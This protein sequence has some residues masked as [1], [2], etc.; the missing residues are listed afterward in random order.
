MFHRVPN[1][2]VC[3]NGRTAWA[4]RTTTSR[5]VSMRSR[6]IRRQSCRCGGAGAPLGGSGKTIT[7]HVSQLW[8]TLDKR[9]GDY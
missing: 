6:R 4:T 3:Q 8:V 9:T 2:A 7:T 5:T 1:H